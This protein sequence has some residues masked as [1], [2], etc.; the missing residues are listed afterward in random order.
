MAGLLALVA[1]SRNKVRDYVRDIRANP[2]AARVYMG[3]GVL[4]FI[5]QALVIASMKYVP[6]GVVALI[7][8][9]TPLVVMPIS[10]FALRKQEN[11]TWATVFGICLTLGGIALVVLNG[12]APA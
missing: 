3:V 2:A 10:Y 4:Q 11:L 6:A 1:A 12:R 5:A 7:S 8:M 9:C